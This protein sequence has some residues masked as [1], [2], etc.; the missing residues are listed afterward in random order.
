[1]KIIKKNGFNLVELMVTV[2]IMCFLFVLSAPT[3][4]A[5]MANL[6]VRNIADSVQMG[7]MKARAES[8]KRNQSVRF[9]LNTDTSWQVLNSNGDIID[10]KSALESSASVSLGITPGG[11][12][13]VTFNGLGFVI[14]N[15]DGTD[16]LSAV[17]LSSSSGFTGLTDL[18]IVVG[19]G[20]TVLTCQ[21][22]V[23]DA[24]DARYC[25]GV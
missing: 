19:S 21:P 24:L 3:Y 12:A 22:S 10:Q 5:W 18:R 4:S 6:R 2:A 20:G 7:L 23:S 16:T 11:A 9:T 1:M 13:T 25:R 14:D 15:V 8:I 17:D